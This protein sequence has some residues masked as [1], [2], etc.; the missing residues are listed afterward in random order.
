MVDEAEGQAGADDIGGVRIRC[1][2][3]EQF[4]VKLW[5]EKEGYCAKGC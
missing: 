5:C 1:E 3:G 4:L 2:M